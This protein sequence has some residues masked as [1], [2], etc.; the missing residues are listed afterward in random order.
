MFYKQYY[1][2]TYK[3]TLLLSNVFYNS[4]IT[5]STLLKDD[6]LKLEFVT[7]VFKKVFS[8]KKNFV[9]ILV[10]DSKDYHKDYRTSRANRYY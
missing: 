3:I 5:N 7:R 8:L 10:K 4:L 9:I 1:I 2:Y 6:S